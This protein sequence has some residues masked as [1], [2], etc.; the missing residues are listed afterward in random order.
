MYKV[1]RV[2]YVSAWRI[3]LDRFH[4]F[5]AP[6]EVGGGNQWLFLGNNRSGWTGDCLQ[7][8]NSDLF[9]FYFLILFQAHCSS[10]GF[11]RK[12]LKKGWM[13]IRWDG[14]RREAGSGKGFSL[15]TNDSVS[16]YMLYIHTAWTNVQFFCF[17]VYSF[18]SKHYIGNSFFLPFSIFKRFRH[19]LL[20]FR[21]VENELKRHI[22]ARGVHRFSLSESK[23]N[24]SS[25]RKKKKEEEVGL[26]SSFFCCFLW[27]SGIRSSRWGGEREKRGGGGGGGW[28]AEPPSS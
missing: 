11:L 8:S 1:K 20:Y 28:K 25:Q 10:V 26:K 9:L 18:C 27:V 4:C 7:I 16:V 21:K 14:G 22:R 2:V 24:V 12:R 13:M 3:K 23:P 17:I 5:K 6:E 15:Y 19:R